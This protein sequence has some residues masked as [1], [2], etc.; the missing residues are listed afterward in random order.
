M[1]EGVK[2]AEEKNGMASVPALPQHTVALGAAC[3]ECRVTSGAT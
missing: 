2:E 1:A 3:L